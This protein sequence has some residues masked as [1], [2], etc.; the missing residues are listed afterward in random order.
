MPKP[1]TISIP[2]TL[3][4]DRAH[5]RIEHGFGEIRRQLGEKLAT[6]EHDWTGDRMDFRVLALGQTVSGHLTVLDERVE[7][8]V[9]LPWLLARLAD[10]IRGRIGTQGTKMLGNK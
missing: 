9:M 4:R 2:H 6:I 10:T 1:L 3:G 5:A 8:E 7:V